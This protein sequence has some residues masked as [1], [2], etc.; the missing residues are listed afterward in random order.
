MHSCNITDTIPCNLL[1][2]LK[3][4]TLFVLDVFEIIAMFEDVDEVV[5]DGSSDGN[6]DHSNKNNDFDV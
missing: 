3:A 1:L 6:D 4:S 5:K 2:F